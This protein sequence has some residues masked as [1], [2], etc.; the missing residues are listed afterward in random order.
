MIS[1]AGCGRSAA[2]PTPGI[3]AA[4]STLPSS[5]VPIATPIPSQVPSTS[6]SL[7]VQGTTAT[8]L[9]VRGDP[10]SA[11]APIGVIAAYTVV[12]ILGK[13]PSGSWYQIQYPKG[14]NGRGWVTSQYVNVK[15]SNSIPVAPFG[16]GAVGVVTQQV[17]VRSGPGTDAGSVGI[18]NARDVLSLVG[19][20]ADG[21]W[22]QILYAAGPGGKGWVAS[23]YVQAAGLDQLPIVGQ[24]GQVIGTPTVTGIPPTAIPTPAVAP[25]DHDSA[26]APA[27]DVTLSPASAR[28]FMYSSDLSA[29]KGDVADWIGFSPY[30]NQVIVSLECDPPEP[31]E[32]RLSAAGV[33]LAGQ[34]LPRCGSSSIA[35]VSP[36]GR[37]LLEIS[38]DPGVQAQ[39]YTR[40][41]VIV[42]SAP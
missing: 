40:F 26:Q 5:P 38:L 25:D 1:I 39:T 35:D 16:T 20:D 13:D 9:N 7:P 6:T 17:N 31:V 41:T 28:S 18:L 23:G 24:T 37:Y 14:P 12:E 3:L 19:K 21:Q 30:G 15:D 42:E 29:P 22:L 8:Q 32:L 2:L 34:S 10:S 4:T 11:S 27:V 33:S 36:G